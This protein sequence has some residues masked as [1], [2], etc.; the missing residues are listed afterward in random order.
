MRWHRPNDRRALLTGY[1]A[2]GALDAD[3]LATWQ[4]VLAIA[5]LTIL[6]STRFSPDQRVQ[7]G[8][9]LHELLREW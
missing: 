4:G 3:S 7:A 9:N 6:T 2:E 1:E 8:A 5:D